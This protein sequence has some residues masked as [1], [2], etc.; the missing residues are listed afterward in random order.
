MKNQILKALSQK[1]LRIIGPQLKLV[2]LARGTVLYSFCRE[3]VLPLAAH[4]SRP[5]SFGPVAVN[6]R[7]VFWEAEKTQFRLRQALF[8][9]REPL[10]AAAAS[11]GFWIESISKM[12]AA[13]AT[14][15]CRPLTPKKDD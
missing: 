2:P 3:T 12:P 7:I 9:R 4:G 15:R 6:S 5:F 14:K 11:S 13:S 10:G 1:E 8:R